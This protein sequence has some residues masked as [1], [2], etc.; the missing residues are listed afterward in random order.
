MIVKFRNQWKTNPLP[1]I[2]IAAL[3][4]RLLAAIFSKGYAMSDDHFVI[5]RIAQ[6]WLDGY[7]DWF[8]TGHPSGFS[9][10]YPGLHFILFYLLKILGVT[11]PQIK[12]L[13]VRLLH[14]LYSMLI[15]I[16]GYLITLKL[17]D[18][19]TAKTVGIFLALFWL[20]P[21][22]SVRNLVE[23]VCI[24]PMMAGFYLLLLAEEK[25]RPAY[26]WIG[27]FLFGFAFAI[28]FQTLLI[29]GS[30]ACIYLVEKKWRPF[31]YFS[32]GTALGLLLIQGLVDLIAWGYPFASFLQYT[33]YNIDYRY[34]YIIG[35]WYRYILTILGVLIPPIS[36]Y[37]LFGFFNTWKKYALLFWPVLI[38]LIFHS[39]FPNK[40]ERF[41]LPILP[42]M[43]ILGL[44]GWNKFLENSSFWQKHTKLL[45]GTWIWFWS[46]NTALLLVL[47]FTYS[48]KTMVEPLTY[49]SAKPDLNALIIEYPGDNMP[50]FPRFYLKADI[51]VY[52][53]SKDISAAE[54]KKKVNKSAGGFP[55][56]FYF[57]GNEQLQ[58]RI[59]KMENMFS[60]H[61]ELEKE[62]DPSNI[63]WLLHAMNPRNNKNQTGYIYRVVKTD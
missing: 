47:T 2:L 51:P 63:D 17:R 30:L 39:Y 22:M 6:R 10:V 23:M 34:A 8:D 41:I 9:L 33:V 31:T 50:W 18:L 4:F 62:I 59:Q 49:L 21:F 53:F 40:Q 35:P 26:W 37:L 42:F 25:N 7:H 19:K 56:Y 36:F 12:M 32:G 38:F 48:K 46:V 58:E 27:G 1:V 57:Y 44:I 14:A 28:R 54:F 24:P 20:L 5:I 55:H 43:I 52:R 15:V 29:T 13:I 61:L 60:I 45:K 11:D 16:F 3:V